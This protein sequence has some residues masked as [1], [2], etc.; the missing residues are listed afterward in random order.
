MAEQAAEEAVGKSDRIDVYLI[1][2]GKYHN[3]DHP[4]LEL[5]KLLAEQPRIKTRIGEDYSDID[6]IC[7][8]DFIISYT[9]D[10]NPTAEQTQRLSEAMRAGKKWFALHGTNSILAFMEDGRVNSPR[11]NEPFMEMLGSQ[12]LSHPPIIPY[13]VEVTEP[14]HPAGQGA[15]PTSP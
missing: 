9:V 8:S 4:R 15:S 6:T 2:G 13:D 3:M 5:L 7:D 10:V 14:E 11:D 12:F 1:V